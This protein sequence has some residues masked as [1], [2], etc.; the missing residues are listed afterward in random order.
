M[1]SIRSGRHAK[2]KLPYNRFKEG[3]IET[4]VAAARRWQCR[5][6]SRINRINIENVNKRR[7]KNGYLHFSGRFFACRRAHSPR[8]NPHRASYERGWFIWVRA[9]TQNPANYRTPRNLFKEEL[10]LTSRAQL[11]REENPARNSLCSRVNLQTFEAIKLFLQRLVTLVGIFY[12]LW[13]YDSI[14][15]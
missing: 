8:E 11:P 4:A 3:K 10:P 13:I 14:C 2:T 5:K 7:S 6:G 1:F 12:V 15:P 9:K